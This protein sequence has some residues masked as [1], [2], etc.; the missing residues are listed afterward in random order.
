M[1]VGGRD[2]LKSPPALALGG[3]AGVWLGMKDGKLNPGLS[4]SLIKREVSCGSG[5]G[6]RGGGGLCFLPEMNWA[7]RKG[8]VCYSDLLLWGNPPV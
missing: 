7:I 4:G 2:G 1:A 3:V 5:W 6:P 8:G